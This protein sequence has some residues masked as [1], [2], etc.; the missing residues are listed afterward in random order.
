MKHER[1]MLFNDSR[2]A[3]QG[4][5]RVK[6]VK[7][8]GNK[9]FTLDEALSRGLKASVNTLKNLHERVL[10]NAVAEFALDLK[11]LVPSTI[12]YDNKPLTI[13]LWDLN[14]TLEGMGDMILR[15]NSVQN[16]YRF[17][18]LVADAPPGIVSKPGKIKA[19][20]EDINS[21]RRKRRFGMPSS[22]GSTIIDDEF[23]AMA[24]TMRERFGLDQLIGLTPYRVSSFEANEVLCD[25]FS[26]SSGELPLSIVSYDEL[27]KFA[28][29][30]GKPF[31]AALLGQVIAQVL[32]VQ[33]DDIEFH[34][35]TGCLF[36]FNNIRADYTRFLRAPKLDEACLGHIDSRYRSAVL[37]IIGLIG[38][39]GVVKEKEIAATLSLAPKSQLE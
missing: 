21:R 38:E 25:Y 30:V 32:A 11:N 31:E 29:Q 8:E 18:D 13:G 14:D 6:Q 7:N 26:S 1:F 39:Y 15:V 3:K 27:R 10:V 37:S 22:I 28:H 12:R 9:P 33:F 16:R 35:D 36:D 19:M 20:V 24:K 2:R 4:R 34:D 5:D 23:F 17:F